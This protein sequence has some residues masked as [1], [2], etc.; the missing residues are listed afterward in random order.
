MPVKEL[1]D[2]KERAL[3]LSAPDR[4]DLAYELLH[5]LPPGREGDFEQA[6]LDEA[7]RRLD[8]WDEGKMP[9]SPWEE[10]RE[11]VRSK[12]QRRG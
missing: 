11:R 1:Q 4:A 10:V 7:E 2:L 8:A 5:S 12:I 6:W 9:A 3:A